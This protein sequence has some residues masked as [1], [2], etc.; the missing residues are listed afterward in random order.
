MKILNKKE[1]IQHGDFQFTRYQYSDNSY[2]WKGSDNKQ[3]FDYVE[4]EMEKE[5][6][7]LINPNKTLNPSIQYNNNYS[8]AKKLPET[9][10]FDLTKA[11]VETLIECLYK[12]KNTIAYDLD[13]S[14]LIVKLD[15]ANGETPEEANPVTQI[16]YQKEITK[17]FKLYQLNSESYI[18][19]RLIEDLIIL[20]EKNKVVETTKEQLPINL[21][22]KLME[23]MGK[24]VDLR[25]S[26]KL[27]DTPLYH[28]FLDWEHK[29]WKLMV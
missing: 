13:K 4:M 18:H 24:H 17:L 19:A 22:L 16:D 11:E 10:G 7:K 15:Q 3:L 29:M 9:K 25:N 1:R 6:Q 8:I 26:N 21:K 23:L 28:S 12:A 5:Y 20:F 2:M 27:T 14:L